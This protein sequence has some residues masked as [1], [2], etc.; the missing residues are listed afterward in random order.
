MLTP[1][2]AFKVGFLSYCVETG[3]DLTQAHALVKTALDKLALFNPLD[4]VSKAVDIA[5]PVASTALGL[6]VPLAL[7]APP[8]AGGIAG[9]SA[10]K[11]SDID[12]TDVK[13]IRKRELIDE[14]Q[15]QTE[16][17]KREKATRAFEQQRKRTGRI[18][19]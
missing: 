15:R 12:D 1:R 9:Y 6:G 17:L 4:V 10:A 8:I 5:K 13:E 16:R 2:E 19:L 18:F 7:A 14:L 11:L 3:L